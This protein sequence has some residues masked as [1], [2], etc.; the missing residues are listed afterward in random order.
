MLSLQN[1]SLQIMRIAY[2]SRP[3]YVTTDNG[4]SGV[5]VGLMLKPLR[6]ISEGCSNGYVK[7]TS[8]KIQILKRRESGG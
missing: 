6:E 8:G 7:K 2:C 1:Y 3:L 5:A 4:P